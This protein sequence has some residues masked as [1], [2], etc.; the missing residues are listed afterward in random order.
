MTAALPG[1]YRSHSKAHRETLWALLIP[2]SAMSNHF[3]LR[4][5]LEMDHGNL[6]DFI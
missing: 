2:F 6:A 4:V 3:V 5:V 1:V